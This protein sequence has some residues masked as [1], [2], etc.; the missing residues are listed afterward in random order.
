MLADTPL[1]AGLDAAALDALAR[2]AIERRAR[3]GETL[4]R[5]GERARGILVLLDGAVRVV[6][7]DGQRRI[8]LHVE[9]AGGT[10][11]EIPT[12]A[13][14]PYPATA[15]ATEPTRYVVLGPEAMAAAVAASPMLAMR[16]L[17][18]LARRA[19]EFVARLDRMAF[20]NVGAR[21]A[22]HL[23]YRVETQRVRDPAAPVVITLGLAQGQ[24]AE[25]L[26]TVREVVVRELRTL[27]EAGIVRPR[28]G[29]RLEIPDPVRLRSLAGRTSTYLSAP[30]GV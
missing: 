5:A 14:G 7:D 1:F 6:R 22:R 27:R 15:I 30:A 17:E 28:G 18:R 19:G 4:F 13:G 2:H 3:T 16:L 29:G 9:R 20:T 25:E 12:F 10:L 23:V 26:G 24:L 8:V 21:L 11:G